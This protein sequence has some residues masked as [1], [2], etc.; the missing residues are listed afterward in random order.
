MYAYSAILRGEIPLQKNTVF[1]QENEKR[2]LHEFAQLTQRVNVCEERLQAASYSKAQRLPLS[3]RGHR[4]SF[5]HQQLTNNTRKLET[6][7][8]TICS[9]EKN[10]PVK[11]RRTLPIDHPT[12]DLRPKFMYAWGMYL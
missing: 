6:Y 3:D 11:S 9:M 2:T 5:A 1:A 8:K 10:P 12:V 4:P 7:C